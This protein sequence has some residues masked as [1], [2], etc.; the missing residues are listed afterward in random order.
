[1]DNEGAR[2]GR[3]GRQGVPAGSGDEHALDASGEL[4]GQER[5]VRLVSKGK[6]EVGFV[7]DWTSR[8]TRSEWL[9]RSSRGRAA[10]KGRA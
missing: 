9:G 6:E 2:E 4:G 5:H 10:V 3:A 8:R 1:M 7:K